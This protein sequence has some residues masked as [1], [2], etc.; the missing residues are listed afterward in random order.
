MIKAIIFDLDG[1]LLETE[2]QTFNFFKDY[3]EKRGIY[4]KNEDLFKKIGR[5]SIDFF[6]DVLLPGQLEEINVQELIDL[7]RYEFIKDLPK[8]SRKIPG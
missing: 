4:L 3:L 8:Y 2:P 1:V 6:N 7:K 5:K